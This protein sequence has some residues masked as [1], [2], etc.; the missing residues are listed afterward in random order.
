MYLPATQLMHTLAAVCAVCA[1]YLP[2]EH[3][4]H[5]DSTTAPWALEYFPSPHGLQVSLVCSSASLYL[6]AAQAVHDAWP[7]TFWKRPFS[8]LAHVIAR[9]PEYRPAP[10]TTHAMPTSFSPGKHATH[11]DEPASDALPIA[12][13]SHAVR[14]PSAEYF[15]ALHSMHVLAAV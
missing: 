1:E 10:Q 9:I 13:R 12:H 5:C 15:P 11:T 4:L 6:P 3:L 2:G 7:C 14:P 8:H